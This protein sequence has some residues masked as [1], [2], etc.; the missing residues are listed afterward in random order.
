MNVL[1]DEIHNLEWFYCIGF[2]V[3]AVSAYAGVPS[4]APRND[5]SS[6]RVSLVRFRKSRQ[7][8]KYSWGLVLPIGYLYR[9]V[10]ILERTLTLEQWGI[11]MAAIVA[12]CAISYFVEY[13]VTSYRLKNL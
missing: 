2:V 8:V 13:V 7:Y 11:V 3:A 9:L 1:P 4:I 5:G 6:R 12:M 10:T